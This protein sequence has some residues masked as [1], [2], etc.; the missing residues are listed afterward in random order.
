MTFAVVLLGLSSLAF[1]G[2]GVGFVAAPQQL[3]EFFTDG[4]P[5]VPSAVTDMRAT[6]GGLSLGLALFFGLCAARR[7][8]IRPGLL[9]ALLAVAGIGAARV[10]GMI[11]DGDPNAFMFVFLATEIVSVGL[12]GFALRRLDS[13]DAGMDQ[14]ARAPALGGARYRSSA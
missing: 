13:A 6:Y 12:I 9:A 10:I 11:A 7:Q 1:A 14:A 3:A 4:A 5:I 2:F 8:W